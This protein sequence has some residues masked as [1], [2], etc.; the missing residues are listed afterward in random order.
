VVTTNDHRDFKP[1]EQ[2]DQTMMTNGG[3]AVSVGTVRLESGEILL[4]HREKNPDDQRKP[5]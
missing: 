5:G 3:I 4:E 1:A 2:F